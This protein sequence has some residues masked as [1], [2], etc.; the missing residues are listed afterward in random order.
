MSNQ[1]L[2]KTLNG[3]Q[4]KRVVKDDLCFQHINCKSFIEKP[5]IEESSVKEIVKQQITASMKTNDFLSIDDM[6]KYYEMTIGNVIN[7]SDEDLYDILQN[8]KYHKSSMNMI[9]WL[10]N[11]YKMNIKDNIRNPIIIKEIIQIF[12]EKFCNCIQYI[13]DT[14]QYK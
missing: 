11:K 3:S 12:S 6:L 1:C 14:N 8:M 5:K 2:C 7:L 9:D 4:C 10:Y 13:G